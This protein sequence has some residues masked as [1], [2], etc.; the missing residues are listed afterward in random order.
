MVLQAGTNVVLSATDGLG[1]SGSSNP[2]LV[3]SDSVI[4]TQVTPMPGGG[5]LVGLTGSSGDVY[6]VLASTNL[7]NW[8]TIASVTNLTGS[9]F[10]V[11]P[12]ATNYNHRFYRLVMP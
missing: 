9:V 8:Q 1:H 6:R 5:I 12:G 2:F 3:V 11:D 7:L 10:F 4:I